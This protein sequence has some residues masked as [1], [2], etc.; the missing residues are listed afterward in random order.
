MIHARLEE[1]SEIMMD[2][3]IGM[4]SILIVEDLP[5]NL[6]LLNRLLVDQGYKT[7]I[8]PNGQLALNWLKNH[9]PDLILL[10]IQLPDINGFE[11]CRQIK[12]NEALQE[13]PVIFLSARDQPEDKVQ[14]FESGG[15]DYVSKPFNEAEVIV[16]V[17]THIQL[18]K[19]TM[20]LRQSSDRLEERVH[21]RTTELQRNQAKYSRLI[22]SLEREYF[23]YLQEAGGEFT[24][25][26]PSISR[27]LGY[28]EDE[29]LSDHRLILGATIGN[30]NALVNTD[31]TSSKHDQQRYEVEVKHK[32]GHLCWLEVIETPIIG[33]DLLVT[34]V[35]GIAHDITSRKIAED[36]LR[37]TASVFS[38]SSEAIMITNA[39]SMIMRV[40]RAFTDI[41]GFSAQEVIG[42]DPAAVGSQHEF[43]ALRQVY[44]EDLK[45]LGSWKGEMWKRHK[46]GEAILV[47][48]RIM[49]VKDDVGDIVHIIYIFSDITERKRAQDRINYLA[50]YDVLTDLPN[51]LLFN[52]RCE[53]ALTRA[54]R[55][56]TMVGIMFIDL[57]N[58]KFINDSMGH[59][60]GDAV[61]VAVAKR[62]LGVLRGQDVLA[63]L[64]GDEFV[65]VLED[66]VDADVVGKIAEK[67]IKSL[68]KPVDIGSHHLH[69]SLSMG[70]SLFPSEA[71]DVATLTKNADAAMYQAKLSG[72]NTYCYYRPELTKKA[73]HRVELEN[74]LHHALEK[75]EF[76]LYYQP[77]YSLCTDQMVGA[78]ALIRWRHPERGLLL[79][80]EFLQ[81][82]E[83]CRLI[84]PIGNFVIDR[85]CE[86]IAEWLKSD[87]MVGSIAI[88]IAAAQLQ[89][90]KLYETIIHSTDKY[91]IPPQ[92]LVVE[93]TEGLI[94]QREHSKDEHVIEQ[95]I[96][97]RQLGVSIA[98]DDFGTG[99]SSLSHL[100]RLP[101]DVLKID[102]SFVDGVTTDVGDRAI[103][104][105][106]IA[107]GNT[108]QLTI[109]AEGVETQ[110]QQS[111]LTEMGC[112]NMQGFLAAQP[113]QHDRFLELMNSPDKK[114]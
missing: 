78:E 65:I 57:D 50:H 42:K 24:D 88:N 37:L 51:R 56:N 96:E 87:L 80:S 105:A 76:E 58:F 64:G 109:T 98:V 6:R 101:I 7:N 107:L 104:Q 21:Q 44:W 68:G 108:L 54:R 71:E 97:L 86:N 35:E 29:F 34:S 89:G 18:Y 43:N 48:Q 45:M 4:G 52:E 53:Q 111:A 99:Y 15:V 90:S 69:V 75:Q 17:K 82:A 60:A 36:E 83:D 26:S 22:E 74:E 46:S 81:V 72:R 12:V 3:S 25:V 2:K 40:N 41:T 113:L 73:L 94:M 92:L 91:Q 19:L 55:R 33:D 20:Q 39:D 30:R 102:R 79:P 66:I 67:I 100:K 112:H 70:I 47:W 28:T 32:D 14:A 38:N 31:K 77:Q 11:I 1:K 59:S 10:D 93:V 103:T 13:V 95:L 61:L 106:I 16:R 114:L 9:V 5:D 63:R 49:A 23:V 8:A 84:I 27:I 85:V 62:V 110:D